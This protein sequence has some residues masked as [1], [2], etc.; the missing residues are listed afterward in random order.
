MPILVALLVSCATSTIPPAPPPSGDVAWELA[1]S[2]TTERYQAKPGQTF[3]GTKKFSKVAPAYP[4]DR[5]LAC[6]PTIGVSASLIV[7]TKGEV[8]EL[9][10]D[11]ENADT[12]PFNG[13]VRRAAMQWKF[14]PLRSKSTPTG[15]TNAKTAPFQHEVQL[16]L[17]MPW[18][19]RRS[20]HEVAEIQEGN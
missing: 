2:E 19:D 15:S 8:T 9:R 20:R 14:Y 17:P 10:V 12:A 3:R 7:N 6:V 13:S 5:L 1:N 18:R 16:H 4:A 11:G